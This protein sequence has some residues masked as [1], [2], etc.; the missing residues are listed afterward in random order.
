LRF[1]VFKDLE[2]SRV[3]IG[4]LLTTFGDD[5]VDLYEVGIDPDH[6]LLV[7]GLGWL[8]FGRCDWLGLLGLKGNQETARQNQ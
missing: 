2:V 4:H 7:A 1:T 8:G 3:Q 5:S 6:I